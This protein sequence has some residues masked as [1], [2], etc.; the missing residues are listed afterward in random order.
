MK[1]LL[2]RAFNFAVLPLKLDITEVL[3]D[4]NKF[5]RAAYWQEYWYNQEREEEY[6]K[7]IF[8]SHKSNLPNKHNTPK[9]LKTFLESIKSEIMDPKNRNNEKSNLP[10]DEIAALKELVKLQRDRIIT[11]KACDKGAGIM[12][13]DFKSYM[14]ACYDH[15]LSS[16]PN[17]TEG[18]EPKMYYKKE[19]EFALERAKKHIKDTLKEALEE[20]NITKEEFKAMDPDEQK[21][22]KVLL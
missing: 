13:L 12:I 10:P 18:E 14:R 2:G 21:S 17:T 20:N 19:D 11:I 22:L 7:P 8:K 9:R 4:F 16:Q 5:A 1:N 15:L 6:E 3:V